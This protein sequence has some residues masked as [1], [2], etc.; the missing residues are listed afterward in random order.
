MF[1]Y[2]LGACPHTQRLLLSFSSAPFL[3][4][5]RRSIERRVG[6][7]GGR[8]AS[9]GPPARLSPARGLR[10]A[11]AAARALPPTAQLARAVPCLARGLGVS[12]GS[13]AGGCWARA[14]GRR[15]QRPIQRPPSPRRKEAKRRR[16]SGGRFVPGGAKRQRRQPTAAPFHVLPKAAFAGAS[17][18][19]RPG[20]VAGSWAAAR[21]AWAS[22]CSAERS[23]KPR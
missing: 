15:R 10:D 19:S 6:L 20:G 21:L 18:L 14:T 16:G 12:E 22:R 5:C 1:V 3:F 2:P 4:S 13:R 23:R 17:K 11:L 7:G 8:G 9:G